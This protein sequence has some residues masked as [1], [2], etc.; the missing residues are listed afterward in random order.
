[1]ALPDSSIWT[2]ALH[3]APPAQSDEVAQAPKHSP[4]GRHTPLTHS[5][6]DVLVQG[7][8]PDLVPTGGTQPSTQDVIVACELLPL[9]TPGVNP[10]MRLEPPAPIRA[11]T[12]SLVQ[13]ADQQ[14]DLE[15]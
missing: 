2:V 11:H 7:A 1:M 13:A 12:A 15:M 10:Q 4:E 5:A 3:V 8:P 6:A 14:M 9:R